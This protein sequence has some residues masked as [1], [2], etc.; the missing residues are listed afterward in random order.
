MKISYGNNAKFELSHK[1]A[2]CWL[3]TLFKVHTIHRLVSVAE[4]GNVSQCNRT[5]SLMNIAVNS[6]KQL[7]FST[8]TKSGFYNFFKITSAV[9]V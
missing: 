8:G 4:S 3:K 9:A 5:F 2:P 1:N 7:T 6:C